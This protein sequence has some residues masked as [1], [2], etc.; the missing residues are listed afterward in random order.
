MDLLLITSLSVSLH[1]SAC[2][3]VDLTLEGADV[4]SEN[5]SFA[6]RCK[7]SGTKFQK[8]GPSKLLILSIN[9]YKGNQLTELDIMKVPQNS[10]VIHGLTTSIGTH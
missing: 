5:R 3:G 1:T 4:R 6:N 8:D 10:K 9:V 7:L 2:K